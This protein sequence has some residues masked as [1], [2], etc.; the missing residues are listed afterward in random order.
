M[1]LTDVPILVG[2]VEH[3]VEAVGFSGLVV[4]VD[5][6]V[7]ESHEITLPSSVVITKTR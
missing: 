6:D 5:D 2:G 4:A 1:R 3:G 7:L